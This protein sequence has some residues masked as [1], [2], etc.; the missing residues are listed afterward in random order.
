M[1][2]HLAEGEA[3]LVRIVDDPMEHHRYQFD[4]GLRGESTCVLDG[5]ATHLVVF[6][7]FTD[8]LV[9]ADKWQIVAGQH[10]RVRRYLG[11]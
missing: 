3:H 6:A 8:A 1:R 7:Q 2:E 4:S 11:R 5:T 10:Q 9:Q